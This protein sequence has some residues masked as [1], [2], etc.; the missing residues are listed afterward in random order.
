MKKGRKGERPVQ[1]AHVRKVVDFMNDGFH[2]YI[3]A[4][5][6]LNAG[7][8]QQGA[9]LASTALEKYFKAVMA[10]R[11][12]ESHGHLKTAHWNSV[13][14]LEPALFAQ[15]DGDFL[16]LCKKCYDLR[17]TEQL[18][19][20]FNV[21][22]AQ[23]E[24]LAELDATVALIEDTIV[25]ASGDGKEAENRYK[26]MKRENDARMWVNNHV[27]AQSVKEAFIYSDRQVVHEIRQVSPG[28]LMEVSYTS[29]KI[30]ADR[31]MMRPALV[32]DQSNPLSYAMSH[33]HDAVSK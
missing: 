19:V 30:P 1:K 8:L 6:L 2:D 33:E 24:F 21:V 13:R 23:R 9:V 18:S 7:L 20:G 22:V 4:R 25:R 16:Q 27:L 12:M 5:V 3:A 17:Y 28:G 14:N 11:G 32:Q 31:S 10:T 26:V 15:I 29:H